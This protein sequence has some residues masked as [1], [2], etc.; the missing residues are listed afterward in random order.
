[1]ERGKPLTRHVE[2]LLTISRRWAVTFLVAFVDPEIDRD[3]ALRTSASG[4]VD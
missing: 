2:A 3:R 1:M 4:Q